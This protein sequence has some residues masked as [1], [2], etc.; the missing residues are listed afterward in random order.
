[1]KKNRNPF[2]LLLSCMIFTLVYLSPQSSQ[3][4]T[5]RSETRSVEPFQSIS[6]SIDANVI[7]QHSDSHSLKIEGAQKL[8]NNIE[9]YVEGST[10]KIKNKEGRHRYFSSKG[11]VTIYLTSPSYRNLTISGSGNI[12][13]QGQIKTDQ[14]QYTIS[15]SG[16][17]VIDQLSAN[18]IE[19]VISGSGNIKLEGEPLQ[20]LKAKISGSGDLNCKNLKT[21][22]VTIRIS[23][24]GDCRVYATQELKA[25]VAGS[26][27][28]YY[29]GNPSIDSQTAGSG[30]LK[31]L[32]Q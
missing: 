5:Q 28:I 8:I 24:S 25:T 9:T 27:N 20:N 21:R 7:I 16:N 18:D 6:L 3:A 10:L 30:R 13:S 17:I 15:G 4:S 32:A 2:I 19:C 31:S 29:N 1:M 26:G 11:K 22:Q 12:N 23:G 14:A